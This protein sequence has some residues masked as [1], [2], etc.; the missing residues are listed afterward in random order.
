MACAKQI[1]CLKDF[2]THVAHQPLTSL[3]NITLLICVPMLLL[4]VLLQ[5]ATLWQLVGDCAYCLVTYGLQYCTVFVPVVSCKIKLAKG[6]K[7]GPEQYHWTSVTSSVQQVH[8]AADRLP[9]S[10]ASLYRV[11]GL[12]PR[13]QPKGNQGARP[14]PI[15]MLLDCSKVKFTIN[16]SLLFHRTSLSIE[17][18]VHLYT[19]CINGG[20]KGGAGEV[21]TLLC[22]YKIIWNYLTLVTKN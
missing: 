5:L 3:L 2:A 12:I 11:I 16:S 1:R 17:S 8:Y 20:G 4:T 13:A 7:P 14:P 15:K 6:L 18:K 21:W 9:A 10:A 19:W 22:R